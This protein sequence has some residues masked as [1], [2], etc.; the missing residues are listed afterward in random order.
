MTAL[1]SAA[2]QIA[3]LNCMMAVKSWQEDLRMNAKK[4]AT[5]ERRKISPV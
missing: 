1:R 3:A 4:Y 5:L 2:M